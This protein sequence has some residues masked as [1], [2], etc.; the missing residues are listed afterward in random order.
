MKPGGALTQR[1]LGLSVDF[2][3]MFGGAIVW[4]KRRRV[5]SFPAGTTGGIG[6]RLASDVDSDIEA[7]VACVFD[8]WF[9]EDI[10]ID[11]LADLEGKSIKS[12][13]HVEYE[14]NF[15]GVEVAGSRRSVVLLYPRVSMSLHT[16]HHVCSNLRAVCY[17]R[18][19]R[20][21][22][23]RVRVRFS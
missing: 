9:L 22:G 14:T 3:G 6:A 11:L 12:T 1:L 7:Y 20:L 21:D 19:S 18:Y 2:A 10:D 23:F 17:C 16:G 5:E 15:G 8:N 4:I 13:C